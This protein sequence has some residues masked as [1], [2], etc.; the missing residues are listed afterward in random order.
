MIGIDV[1]WPEVTES[2]LNLTSFH[3]NC[4][5]KAVERRKLMGV[6]HL[7]LRCNSHEVALT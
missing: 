3:R 7:L 1:M 4:L 5:E 2:D 6:F